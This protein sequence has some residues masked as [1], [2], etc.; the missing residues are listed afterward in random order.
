M[1]RWNETDRILHI[2][3]FTIV[4][5]THAQWLF[6]WISYLSC[7]A[8]CVGWD[9]LL[10]RF[11]ARVTL[12]GIVGG[13]GGKENQIVEIVSLECRHS[14]FNSIVFFSLHF[15]RS[16]IVHDIVFVE[17]R[18]NDDDGNDDD[19]GK[20]HTT[21]KFVASNVSSQY[22]RINMFA[23][24]FYD[25]VMYLFRSIE[26]SFFF[27]SFDWMKIIS[28]DWLIL[29][30]HQREQKNSRIFRVKFI[31]VCPT[32]GDVIIEV[33][34]IFMTWIQTHHL[35]YHCHHSPP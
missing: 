3:K 17:F 34:N 6:H 10:H 29:E 19:D 21:C 23:P 15:I 1:Q 32:N 14:H 13:I 9:K 35:R 28:D 18:W 7:W 22:V 26:G 8:H 12:I 33:V 30:R 24:P 31:R 2:G 27:E 11:V 4:N 16:M 5:W 20:I 25:S